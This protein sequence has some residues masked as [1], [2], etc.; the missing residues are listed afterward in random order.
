[1]PVVAGPILFLLWLDQGTELGRNA[2]GFSLAAITPLIGVLDRL[3]MGLASLDLARDDCS[4]LFGLVACSAF[5][6]CTAL[7]GSSVVARGSVP[8]LRDSIPSLSCCGASASTTSETRHRL[9]DAGRRRSDS[10]RHVAG[11]FRRHK[12]FRAPGDVPYYLRDTRHIHSPKRRQRCRDRLAARIRPRSLLPGCV[13]H[14]AGILA[15]R[16][17]DHAIHDCHSR[18]TWRTSD[19]RIHQQIGITS[20][21]V[22]ASMPAPL[23]PPL[24]RDSRLP[25]LRIPA[26]DAYSLCAD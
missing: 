20:R 4:E 2:A 6:A 5:G 24:T 17:R 11:E 13:L 23:S 1:M 19:C 22:N 18:C 8:R 12:D 26:P 9:P 10:P 25:T 3:C 15:N 14:G 16:Q 21:R 7:D